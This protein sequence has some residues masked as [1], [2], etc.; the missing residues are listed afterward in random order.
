MGPKRGDTR[1]GTRRSSRFR[2]QDVLP[3]Q[4]EDPIPSPTTEPI[5]QSFMGVQTGTVPETPA[6]TVDPTLQQT[7]ELLT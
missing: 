5:E 1:R 6:Q 2:G 3:E 4:E 7:I